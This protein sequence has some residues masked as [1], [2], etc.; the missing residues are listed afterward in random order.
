MDFYVPSV[1][2]FITGGGG[3]GG[4][5]TQ[6]VHKKPYT[7]RDVSTTN[8]SCRN[9]KPYSQTIKITPDNNC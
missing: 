4:K 7:L 8:V 3:G 6:R 5:S 1:C 9:V 2:S